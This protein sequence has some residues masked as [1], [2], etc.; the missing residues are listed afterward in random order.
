MVKIAEIVKITRLVPVYKDGQEATSIQVAKFEFSDGSECGFNVV[1]QK[2]L[3]EVGSSAVYIQPDYCLTDNKLFAG[4]VAPGGDAKKS[5]LG[6]QNRIRAIKF[7]FQFEGSSDPIYS[8]GILIPLLEVEDFL[9]DSDPENYCFYSDLPSPTAYASIDQIEDLADKLGITKYEEPETAGSGLA[10]GEFPSFMYKTDEPNAL[11]LVSHIKRVIEEGQELGITIKRDGSSHTTYFKQEGDEWRVG[12][13]SRSMEK[14]MEQLQTTG[15]VSD[16]GLEYRRHFDRETM[17]KGWFCEATEQFITDEVAE[18]TLNPVQKEVKD[19]WV[20]LANSSGL[21][22]KGLQY[23]KDFGVQLAFRGE[24]I[25]Q[26]LKGSGNKVN[27]DANDKQKLVLFGI[28]DLSEG[29]AK[30]LNYS[31]PHNL[32][33]VANILGLEYTPVYIARF[34][35]YEAL[36]EYC[37]GIFAKEKADGRIIEGVVIRTMYTNDLSCKYMNQEY[38]SKK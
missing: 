34:S 32:R 21:V 7:N 22:E 35:T 11:N 29:Y 28:D 23:C 25:G 31:S 13:C 33:Y 6:K 2:G 10:A 18:S 27:P 20:E 4:F 26:G 12:V 19:S 9:I 37:E 5:R 16:E 17:T 8:N 14:R 36:C 3:Y 24:I 38:D 15:Y 30:R 1:A